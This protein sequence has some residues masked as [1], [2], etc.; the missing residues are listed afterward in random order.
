MLRGNGTASGW[1][2]ERGAPRHDLAGSDPDGLHGA[3][4]DPPPPPRARHP[5]P[6]NAPRG[7]RGSAGPPPPP[8]ER[9]G[10][11]AARPERYPA[12]GGDGPLQ[13]EALLRVV[14]LGAM[15]PIARAALLLVSAALLL[16]SCGLDSPM[17]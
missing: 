9:H 13:A 6:P 5:G 7:D 16:A 15:R 12:D 14:F 10:D 4:Q 2:G 17:T 1:R 11:G 3:V 8:D